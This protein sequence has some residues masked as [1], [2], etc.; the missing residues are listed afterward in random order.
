M[1]L[2][3]PHSQLQH[4]LNNLSCN[5]EGAILLSREQEETMTIIEKTV[6]LAAALGTS[7]LAFA[8]TLV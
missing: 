6:G 5:C 2:E 7:A 3:L 8:L 1:Q 4:F